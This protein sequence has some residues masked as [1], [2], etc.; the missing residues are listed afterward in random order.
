MNMTERSPI[1]RIAHRLSPSAWLA[2][3]VVMSLMAAVS[4][5]VLYQ[6]LDERAKD[7]LVLAVESIGP[8]LRETWRKTIVRP[9]SSGLSEVA[10][11]VRVA[12]LNVLT[13]DASHVWISTFQ[14]FVS[15][16]EEEG[17]PAPIAPLH[18]LDPDWNPKKAR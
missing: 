14:D 16:P 12:P 7:R 9:P 8:F 5:W 17:P 15:L 13:P 1:L 6:R 10:D 18:S 2:V 11:A 4:T 3:A